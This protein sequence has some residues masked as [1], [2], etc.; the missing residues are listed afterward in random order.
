MKYVIYGFVVLALLAGAVLTFLRLNF[1]TISIPRHTS[2]ST[3][4]GELRDFS[5]P[6]GF[7]IYRFAQNIENARVM[8]FDPQGTLLV[9]ETSAGKIVALPDHNEDQ[10]ADEVITVLSGLKRPHGIAFDC[11]A[12]ESCHLYVAEEDALDRFSYDP[13]TMQASN[14]EKV[15]DLP[16]GGRH[17]TRTLLFMPTPYEHTLLISVGSSCNVCNEQD[18][19]RAKILAYDTK[20]GKIEEFA[21]GLRNA[22]FLAINPTM[23]AIWATEMGRDGLGDDVPPDEINIIEKGKNYGWPNC[24]GDNIH[25]SDF[26]HNTYIRNPCM[27]PFET[28][29]HINLQAHSAPLGIAFVPEE[30]WPETWWYDAIVAYHGSW[31]RTS[32]TGYKLVRIPLDAKGRE[33]GPIEDFITGWMNSSGT[34]I[35]RPVDVL[36][37]PGGTMYISD[38]QSGVIY[39]MSHE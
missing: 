14:K 2:P 6:A 35:G 18:D 23:G 19:K 24:Y 9:S 15:A 29:A 10:V 38:D 1:G 26:D 5:V 12:Y 3:T 8:V 36:T 7:H 30:G 33:T 16:G 39:K 4:A 27:S 28:P 13:K 11:T 37:Q 20:T 22:V 31:N 25:D 32:P 17:F 21:K 34:T